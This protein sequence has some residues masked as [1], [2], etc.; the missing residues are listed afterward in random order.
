M[1]NSDH[2]YI[3]VGFFRAPSPILHSRKGDRKGTRTTTQAPRQRHCSKAQ[4]SFHAHHEHPN[5][6]MTTK[7]RSSR[8]RRDVL[9]PLSDFEPFNL[10]AAYNPTPAVEFRQPPPVSPPPRPPTSPGISR[11]TPDSPQKQ[12]ASLSK[13]LRLRMNEVGSL[14]T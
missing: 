6:T 14:S 9:A 4:A 10:E 2:T 7:W 1:Q 11:P 5:P 12:A 3:F 8:A 13:N